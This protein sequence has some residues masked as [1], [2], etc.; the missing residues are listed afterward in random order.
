[1]SDYECSL[2][3]R[4]GKEVVVIY[5]HDDVALV[6]SIENAVEIFTPIV[7]SAANERADKAE[8]ELKQAREGLRELIISS[9]LVLGEWEEDAIANFG[10]IPTDT[11][12]ARLRKALSRPGVIAAKEDTN[13]PS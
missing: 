12:G 8:D 11:I 10:I 5:R 13:E 7:S 4:P 2:E 3:G 9:T 6:L 1:M